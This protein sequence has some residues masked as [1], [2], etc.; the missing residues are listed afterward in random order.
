VNDEQLSVSY[1][2]A[3]APAAGEPTP[4]Q[5]AADAVAAYLGTGKTA[6][7]PEATATEP[8]LDPKAEQPA[9]SLAEQ[10]EPPRAVEPYQLDPPESIS[11]DADTEQNRAVLAG[12]SQ[13]ASSAGVSRQDAETLV[14][15][16]IEAQGIF[17][18]GEPGVFDQNDETY[19][20]SDAARV[21]QRYWKDDYAMHLAA[22]RKTV[23]GLGPKFVEW[24]DTSG[25]GNSPAA[26]LALSQL[27]N[28]KMS[29]A[30]ADEE[31]RAMSGR[32]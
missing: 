17:H 12:F 24:L 3:P 13:A 25:M 1:P 26:I 32:S 19:T 6:P 28:L 8:P 14:D 23:H 4:E 21:L 20:P 2:A 9:P 31:L 22:V 15:L 11:S 27:G 5:K 10:Q 29:K 16:Y 18:Y 7:A 30:Q